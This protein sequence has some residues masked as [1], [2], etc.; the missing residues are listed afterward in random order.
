M[1]LSWINIHTKLTTTGHDNLL[2]NHQTNPL[3]KMHQNDRLNCPTP[4]H[5]SPVSSAPINLG[6][7]PPSMP[8]TYPQSQQRACPPY[9][10]SCQY[11]AGYISPFL[12]QYLTGIT[13]LF[14]LPVHPPWPSKSPEQCSTRLHVPLSGTA[15]R[16]VRKSYRSFG[17]RVVQGNAEAYTYLVFF[18]PDPAVLVLVLEGCI[19]SHRAQAQSRFRGGR[20]SIGAASSTSLFLL[21]LLLFLSLV[22]L[23]RPTKISGPLFLRI[24]KRRQRCGQCEGFPGRGSLGQI[25]PWDEGIF[26]RFWG[27]CRVAVLVW[28]NRFE[29][30]GFDGGCMLPFLW[31]V[32]LVLVQCSV[33]KTITG[34][35]LILNTTMD[36]EQTKM[37]RKAS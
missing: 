35:G 26:V 16:L 2:H 1:P 24:S 15:Y 27:G 6:S 7:L 34:L 5:P 20:C 19:S 33:W 14:P 31:W 30:V 25:Q 12:S 21:S 36:N 28:E 11:P 4:D 37:G 3:C 17:L 10:T 22:L 18:S 32:V 23:I 29:V 13:C 8:L 9:T